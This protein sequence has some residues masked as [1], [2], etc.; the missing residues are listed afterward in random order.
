MFADKVDKLILLDVLNNFP[1]PSDEAYLRCTKVVEKYIKTEA[2]MQTPT[3]FTYTYESA[4]QR[5]IKGAA[6][7]GSRLTD[8]AADIL[9]KRWMKQIKGTDKFVYTRDPRQVTISAID[10]S[11]TPES[12]PQFFPHIKA[13]TL[14]V[15]ATEGRGSVPK[16]EKEWDQI[17]RLFTCFEN[18]EYLEKIALS[19]HHHIHLTNPEVVAPFINS[20]LQRPQRKGLE[21]SK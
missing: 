3:T 17:A 5:L 15:V 1:T 13:E 16:A 18:T 21:K 4:R 11:H 20:F 8:E 10:V 7:Q 2:L 9:L 19:G 6:L 14:H 12:F